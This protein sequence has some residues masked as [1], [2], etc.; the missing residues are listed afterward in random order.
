MLL[1][2]CSA[3]RVHASHATSLIF[4]FLSYQISTT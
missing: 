4:R 1:V 3:P 2:M